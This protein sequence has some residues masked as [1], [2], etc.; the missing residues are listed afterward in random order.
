MPE[1][2]TRILSTRLLNDS[3]VAEAATAGITIDMISFIEIEPIQSAEVQQEIEHAFLQSSSV[4][5]T[6]MNAVEAVITKLKSYRPDWTIY[7]VGNTTK[8]L[9]KKYFDEERIAGTANSA[10][11]LAEL[12]VEKHPA[13]EV[14]FFCA[15]QRRDELPGILSNN[16][17]QVK[18]IIVYKTHAVPHK[19]EK[20]YNGILFFSPSAVGSFFSSNQPDKQTI[21]FAI[22]NTTAGEIK[23]YLP[24]GKSGSSYKIIISNEPGKEKLLKQVMEYYTAL[25]VKP[26]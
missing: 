7:C 10:A 3:L 18:E 23:K 1:N 6:S 12:I 9:I 16:N 22:G 11:E 26:K 4:V 21:L 17:I 8:Q 25:N 13:G 20:N 14:I 2:K 5:F 19:I 15:D 24:A